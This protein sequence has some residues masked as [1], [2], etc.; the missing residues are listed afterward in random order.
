[1]RSL[2]TGAEGFVGGH[3]LRALC[4]DGS[5][6]VVAGT[7]SAA[8]AVAGAAGGAV[9]WVPLDVTSADSLRTVIAAMRP[10]RVYHLAGQSSVGGSFRDPVATW[11]V[12]AMGT[13]RLLQVLA[14]EGLTSTRVLVVS[15][16][17]VYGPVPDHAQPIPESAPLRPVSPYGASKAAAE[18]AG[19]QMAEAGAVEVV[20]ARSFNHTGPGQDARFVL[21]SMARQLVR[22]RSEGDE[23]VLHVGNLDV[24]RDFLD[25]RDVV[26]AYLRLM[27]E[28]ENGGVYNV[29]S[30]VA[31]SLRELVET[32]IRLSGTGARVSVDPDRFRPVDVPLLVGDAHK[33]RSLGWAPEVELEETL[34]DLLADSGAA[35]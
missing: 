11:E 35:A 6:E 24:W 2:V 5:A 14:E 23:P 10:E 16:A 4:R 15:S 22:M 33:L 32:L 7:L 26:R 21:P 9:R 13:L 8:G 28:G 34:R 30:G 18:L 20:V 17:E 31:R 1:M 27:E 19:L 12:N 25:V 29:C 3:L